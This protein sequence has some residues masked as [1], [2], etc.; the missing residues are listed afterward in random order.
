MNH[1][2]MNVERLNYDTGFPQ[3]GKRDNAH[4]RLLIIL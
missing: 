3:K 4:M 2:R 1:L